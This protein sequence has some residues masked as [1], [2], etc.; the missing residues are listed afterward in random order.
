MKNS[1]TIL[2]MSV[3]AAALIVGAGVVSAQAPSPAPA[4]Q[5]GAPAAQEPKGA[6]NPGAVN[7]KAPGAG[8]KSGQADD[9][10]GHK[11][12]RA[13]H[14]QDAPK[15]DMRSKGVS[16]ET[17]SPGTTS[18][19]IKPDARTKSGMTTAPTMDKTSEK[20]V[21][22]KASTTGQGATAAS[23]NLSAE[24]RTTVRTALRQHNVQPMTNVN[25]SITVGT[26]VPRSVRYHALPTELV[27]IYPHWRGY[28][29]FL[30]G[31]Q[32]VVVNPRTHQIVAVLDA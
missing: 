28:E 22:P 11:D 12:G 8:L 9:K 10:M 2:L 18:S 15:D 26:A 13:Q 4:A 21:D 32:V 3:A 17:K 24:Q 16:P 1:K 6:V 7:S 31:D 5:Q 25:F 29:Y 27:H 20:V 23:A 19:E 14:V 30:V